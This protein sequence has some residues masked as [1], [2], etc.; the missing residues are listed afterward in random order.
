MTGCAIAPCT[1]E[2]EVAWSADLYASPFICAPCDAYFRVE[3]AKA[4]YRTTPCPS[5]AAWTA[6]YEAQQALGVDAQEAQA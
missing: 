6:A 3:L 1:R 2:A 4:I 5:W